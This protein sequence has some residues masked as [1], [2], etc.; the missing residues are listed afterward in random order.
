VAEAPNS[1]AATRP[2][3]PSRR[4]R[5]R[6]RRR[7][8]GGGPPGAAPD[9]AAPDSSAG[10]GSAPES[11]APDGATQ[12]GADSDRDQGSPVIEAG[13]QEGASPAPIVLPGEFISGSAI[14][15]TEPREAASD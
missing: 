5:R 3:G 6:R 12:D 7:G 4:R 8:P 1:E 14:V 2:E 9:G 10:E 15:Q 13:A 11:S